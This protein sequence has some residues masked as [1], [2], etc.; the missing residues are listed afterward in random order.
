ME[1][2]K[3]SYENLYWDLL[4]KWIFI[5]F[6]Q[7]WSL[8]AFPQFWWGPFCE[9][10]TKPMTPQLFSPVG[11]GHVANLPNKGPSNGCDHNAIFCFK[12]E[13][14]VNLSEI[15]KQ[16]SLCRRIAMFSRDPL[17]WF[18]TKLWTKFITTINH[19]ITSTSLTICIPS[20]QDQCFLPESLHYNH[21]Q[22]IVQQYRS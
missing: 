17:Q 3:E 4:E 15:I 14:E 6:S 18:S 12:W 1:K 9:W 7:V 19:S 8:L 21:F 11:C 10:K 2:E 20:I 22:S 13:L 5:S 16:S